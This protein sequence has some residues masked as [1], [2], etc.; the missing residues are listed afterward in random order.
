MQISQE[1][2][3]IRKAMAYDLLQMLRQENG[4]N[5]TYEELE[6]MIRFYIARLSQK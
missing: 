6:E 4:R 1:S 5:Y 3:D 2:M